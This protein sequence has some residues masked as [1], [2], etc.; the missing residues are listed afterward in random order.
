[1]SRTQK[2]RAGHY[3]VY[4]DKTHCLAVLE[5]GRHFAAAVS[6]RALFWEYG[7]AGLGDSYHLGHYVGRCP[8]RAAGVGVGFVAVDCGCGSYGVDLLGL[9]AYDARFFDIACDPVFEITI[10]YRLHFLCRYARGDGRRHK[11]ERWK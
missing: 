11:E 5:Y 2:N 3:D 8:W 10:F 9:A 7:V 4:I 6:G 1:M